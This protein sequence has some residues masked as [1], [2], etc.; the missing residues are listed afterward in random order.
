MSDESPWNSTLGNWCSYK[1]TSNGSLY[2]W[3]KWNLNFKLTG[4]QHFSFRVNTLQVN[5]VQYLRKMMKM[6][7]H[8]TEKLAEMKLRKGKQLINVV[9]IKNGKWIISW[10]TISL[11]FL[12]S[13]YWF[14]HYYCSQR[15]RCR[16]RGL[17]PAWVQG[18]V[19]RRSSQGWFYFSGQC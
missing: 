8:L 16:R 19:G 14:R 12:F 11:L 10:L 4:V 1:L 9:F 18:I 2:A 7:F 6:I 15:L 3:R 13:F 17:G 5:L